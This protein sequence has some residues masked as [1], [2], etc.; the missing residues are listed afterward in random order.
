MIIAFMI[1]SDIDMEGMKRHFDPQYLTKKLDVTPIHSQTYN[2]KFDGNPRTRMPGNP[3]CSSWIYRI[4][5]IML[6]EN[7]TSPELHL[8]NLLKGI[9]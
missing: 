3:Y 4:T 8:I 9:G 1:Y 6:E 2:P 7:N 5:G